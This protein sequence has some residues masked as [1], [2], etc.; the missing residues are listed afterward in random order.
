MDDDDLRGELLE[1]M[2]EQKE[3]IERTG[4]GAVGP[5]ALA[6][7]RE[8]REV[9]VRH[10]D[11]LRELLQD[12]DWP[13]ASRVGED[14]ARGAWLVAQHADTQLD[15][16]RLAVRLLGEAVAR[17][18][19][20]R[21]DLAFLQDRVAVNEG[22]LQRYGTQIAD[23]VDGRPVPWPCLDPARLD[24]LRAE[25]GIEPFAVNAARFT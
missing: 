22:S 17:G 8:Q 9:F 21:R 18:E 2:R 7:R 25:V 16:Q 1:M 14:A 4:G 15:V 20:S 10:A 19:A 3:L 12:A 13:I 6:V 23:V 24:E 11:R 5:V